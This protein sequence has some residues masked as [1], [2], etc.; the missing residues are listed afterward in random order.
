MH[1]FILR[2][3]LP[4]RAPAAPRP[5]PPFRPR[6]EGLEGR[7]LPSTFVVTNTS[8]SAAAGSGS[9]RRAL[10]DSNAAG[11]G[12][13]VISFAIPG[14]GVHTIS[15]ASALPSV[16]VPALIDGASQ[17][18]FT[19]ANA[20][21]VVLDGTNAGVVNGL[22]LAANGCTVRGLAID[23]FKSG[24]GVLVQSS[25][26]V[27]GANYLGTDATGT[28]AAGNDAGVEVAG[29]GADN[30][31]R[32]DLLSA[33][34]AFGVGLIG[35]GTMVSANL[36][37]TDVSGT[38]P[39]G[40]NV[41]VEV[42]DCSGNRIGGNVISGNMGT[43]LDFFSLN[44]S[45]PAA[46]NLAANNLIG[47]DGSGTR[48]LPNGIGVQFR[49]APANTLQSN[50][51]SGNR[52]DGVMLAFVNSEPTDR[53]L[54]LNNLIGVDVFG[55]HPLGNGG[56]GIDLTSGSNGI[57]AG[58]TVAANAGGGVLLSGSD[59]TGLESGYFVVG[60]RVGTDVSGTVALGNAGRAGVE[61]LAKA[62]NNVID[63]NLIA[64]NL[65]DGVHVSDPGTVANTVQRNLIGVAVGGA[66]LP[67]GLHGVEVANGVSSTTL[68]ANDVLFN[69][70][71]G[72][73]IRDSGTVR[74]H[75][76]GNNSSFN[77]GAGVMVAAGPDNNFVGGGT[78]AGNTIAF[79]GQAG[80]W[81]DG[82]TTTA[83][84]IAGNSIF[85]NTGLGG[86][87]L[88]GGANGNPPA[89]QLAYAVNAGQGTTVVVGLLQHGAAN[90]QYTLQFFDSPSGGG[91]GQ[92]F[93]G[94]LSV[95][96]DGNGNATFSDAF[97]GTLTSLTATTDAFGSSSVFSAPA[98]VLPL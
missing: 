6:L 61:V 40:N 5:R 91:Q 84:L 35:S 47:T 69:R 76:T 34:T 37:G 72:V 41:G 65:F 75:I 71:H 10:L 45:S 49:G 74:T 58:N 50:V 31:I 30:V 2:K 15:P 78:G 80:V 63:S 44:S 82:A 73:L 77:A 28:L 51:I 48:P 57:L 18:G 29:S 7:C 93:L 81:A 55:A 17:P 36:I 79:N 67:N 12:P 54:L 90:A 92:T 88:T 19:A 23:N 86:I 22:T 85:G 21:Q 24:A 1:S 56:A 11:P 3:L 52:S 89:P 94:N 68:F 16:T 62:S 9:L 4:G 32:N 20:P 60:N 53:D 14:A 33:N 38:R 66:P 59:T 39:L 25:G 98:A 95:T 87:A 97:A 64:G 26:N 8:D 96:T 13:N 46:N 70:G 43:G 27:I 83:V 42:T